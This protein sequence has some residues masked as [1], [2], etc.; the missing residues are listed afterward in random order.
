MC[1]IKPETISLSCVEVDRIEV[2]SIRL[3][4]KTKTG[5]IPPTII[6]DAILC[7]DGKKL[8]LENGMYLKLEA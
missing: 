3:S 2:P 5:G 8:L 1:F 4:L 7:E 6:T